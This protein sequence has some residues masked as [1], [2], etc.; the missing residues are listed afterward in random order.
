MPIKTIS[1][2]DQNPFTKLANRILAITKTEDYLQ[3]SQKQAQVK[4]LE[5][6]ID[7]MVYELYSLTEKEIAI[8][9]DSVK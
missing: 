4:A 6:E 1:I 3:S 5:G 8:V 7:R 2:K 9:E